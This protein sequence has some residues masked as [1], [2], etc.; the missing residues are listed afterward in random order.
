CGTVHKLADEPQLRVIKTA[1][2]RT[3][4]IG[5]L[6]RYTLTVENV[7]VVNVRDSTVV[8]TPPQGFS[9]VEGS[10]AVDD[11]DDAFDLAPSQS[12]LRIGGLDVAAGESA[13][14]VYLLRVGAG[15]RHGTQ[16]N[17]AQA[18]DAAGN[19]IS[20]TATAQV[21]VEADPLLDDSL[22]FGT[23]FNDRD[24]DGWQDS[25]A[26]TGVRVQ[27]GFAPGAYLAGSTT[28]DRGAGAE[29]VADA[30]APLLHGITVGTIAA[31]QSEADPGP[32]VV[33][34]QRLT[35]AT[36]TNDFVLT[37]D[38]GVTVRVD[39]AGTATVDKSDAAA[40]GLNAA[41]PTV[42]RRI[43]QGEGGVVVDYVIGNAGLDERGIPGVRIASVDGLL[44]ETD[45]YG[46]YH[47]A[48]VPGG[49]RGHRNFI[50]KLDPSTLPPGTPLTTD[51][52]LV[53]RITP[54]IPV[55]FD[56]GVQLPAEV[57][58][59]G[60]EDVELTLGEVIFAPGSAEVRDE[61]GPA[62]AKM[63]EQ[64][65]AYGGGTVV[66]TANGDHQALAFDRASAVRELLLAQVTPEHRQALTVNVHTEVDD[67][68]AGV[69]E[70]GALLGTV[71][72]DTDQAQIKPEF[73]PLL[74][75]VA[76]R[77][78]A[79]GGGAIAVVGHTDVR[80]SHAY[81]AELGLRRARAVYEALAER[82][83]PEVRAQVRVE[84]SNDPT[85]PVGPERK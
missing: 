48:D 50:L 56:F 43:A 19:A 45:Q 73:A 78:E 28:L 6:V 83:S 75:R 70:G 11:G 77:L 52:P 55:R 44:I 59:G 71:L 51:N 63:A 74:D 33:I 15:V 53:R 21:S 80:G 46:R 65:D 61:Y 68:V 79:M 34:R 3:A 67:L 2:V 5:D 29:P 18:Q 7:G 60:S 81:N 26:L 12:P 62:I 58:P 31:R 39:A 64:V 23:V 24:G 30:S 38:Q 22:I 4:N 17:T 47:L 14:I 54:G 69:T 37:S 66:I 57:I 1:G 82:L 85:A 49:A 42:E 16:V 40:K 27:G 25:A 41:A 10:L 76:A 72:F 35:E 13:T 32:Q 36:F 9:Y 84:S 20:N 8:D